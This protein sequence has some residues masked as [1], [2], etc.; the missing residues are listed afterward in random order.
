LGCLGWTEW[1]AT[2]VDAERLILWR[3]L[4]P[5]FESEVHFAANAPQEHATA[6]WPLGADAETEGAARIRV[7]A[8]FPRMSFQHQRTACAELS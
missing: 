3:N 8:G 7:D 2:A 1:S 5:W 4:E 6:S